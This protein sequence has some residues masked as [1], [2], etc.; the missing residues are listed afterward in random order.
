MGGTIVPLYFDKSG[1]NTR[2]F[3]ELYGGGLRILERETVSPTGAFS[4]GFSWRTM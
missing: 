1:R 4:E 3:Y 2:I